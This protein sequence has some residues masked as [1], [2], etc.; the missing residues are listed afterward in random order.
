M[1]PRFMASPKEGDMEGGETA[2]TQMVMQ[3]LY[4]QGSRL[5][6]EWVVYNH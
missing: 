6:P 3:F 1:L 2:E 5:P 4:D